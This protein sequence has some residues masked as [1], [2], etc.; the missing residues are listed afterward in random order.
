MVGFDS[1]GHSR[2]TQKDLPDPCE[3]DQEI[4]NIITRINGVYETPA[5]IHKRLR[6]EAIIN[7]INRKRN[8]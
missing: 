6:Q 7:G 8:S 1:K 4:Y 3:R 5:Q 2:F